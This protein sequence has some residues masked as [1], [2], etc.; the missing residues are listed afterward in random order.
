MNLL[1]YQREVASCNDFLCLGIVEFAALLCISFFK[2]IIIYLQMTDPGAEEMIFTHFFD[3]QLRPAWSSDLW[4]A[5]PV[6]PVSSYFIQVSTSYA[7]LNLPFLPNEHRRRDFCWKCKEH[8]Y[9]RACFFS[10]Y[11]AMQTLANFFLLFDDIPVELSPT[12]HKIV[13]FLFP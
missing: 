9:V 4:S 1:E 13:F 8:S 12:F 2:P 10:K 3:K 6:P 11:H 5:V 7:S